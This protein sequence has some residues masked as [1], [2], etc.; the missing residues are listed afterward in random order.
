MIFKCG[1][2]VFLSFL[3]DTYDAFTYTQP[4]FLIIIYVL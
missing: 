4:P 1:K 2:K 3:L